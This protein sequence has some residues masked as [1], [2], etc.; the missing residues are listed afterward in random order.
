MDSLHVVFEENQEL[1][2]SGAGGVSKGEWEMP[3]GE[4]ARVLTIQGQVET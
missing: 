3:L 1:G 2:L 4:K